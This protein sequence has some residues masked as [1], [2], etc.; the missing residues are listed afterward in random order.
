[1]RVFD[2][3]IE[4]A[5]T[6]IGRAW[7]E[8]AKAMTTTMQYAWLRRGELLGLRWRDVE[9]SHPDSPRLHV[10]ETWVRGHRSEPKTDDGLRTIALDAP[11]AEALW[12]HRRRTVYR[13]PDD[14]VFCHPHKGTPVS[15]GYF[16]K[17]IKAVLERAG[18]QRQM[19]EYHDCGWDEPGRDH[20]DG[21]PRRLQDHAA[22]H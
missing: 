4:E 1:M 7:L 12:Q 5:D 16:N 20:A 15:S 14:V 3:L 22:L 9:L 21:G 10:R 17:I 2:E 19:R 13:G 18:V 8:T 11:L 6:E